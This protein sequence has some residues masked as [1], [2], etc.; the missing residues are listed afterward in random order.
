[1]PYTRVCKFEHIY[2]EL[3]LRVHPI[4]EVMNLLRQLLERFMSVYFN[5][6][7]TC[8]TVIKANADPSTVVTVS[9]PLRKFLHLTL[10]H[11]VLFFAF[12]EFL[13]HQL[14]VRDYAQ[15]NIGALVI[16]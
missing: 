3:S 5:L 11:S 10:Q 9:H 7:P 4:T 6:V 15:Q 2:L 16:F 14:K 1:M 8:I 12:F 13:P